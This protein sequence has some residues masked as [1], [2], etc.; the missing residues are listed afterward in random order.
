MR[1]FKAGQLKDEWGEPLQL[2]QRIGVKA[3]TAVAVQGRVRSADKSTLSIV[4]CDKW[5][6]YGENCVTLDIPSPG[7]NQWQTFNKS[8]QL[9]ERMEGSVFAP[10]FVTVAL[11]GGSI[12]DVDDFAM[13]EPQGTNLIR[14]GDFEL[15]LYGWF[16][17]SDHTHLPWHTKSLPLGLFFDGGWL[18]VSAF[19]LLALLLAARLAA[20]VAEGNRDGVVYAASL[21]GFA[22]VGAFDTVIDAPR[23]ALLFL[24][25]CTCALSTAHAR[26]AGDR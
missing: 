2:S 26:T 22:V 19:G 21:M 9:P 18:L 12:V 14:N 10:R 7:A 15:G 17:V 25:V 8:I 5:L 4:V 20:A 13:L 11:V 6:L 16:V 23:V 1:L 3:G 24:L